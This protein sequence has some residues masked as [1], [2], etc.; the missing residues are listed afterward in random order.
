[1]SYFMRV[2]IKAL[3]LFFLRF[4]QITFSFLFFLGGVS[5]KRGYQHAIPLCLPNNC[6]WDSETGQCVQSGE[7]R[8]SLYVVEEAIEQLRTIKGKFL[9]DYSL[10]HCP[11]ALSFFHY[12]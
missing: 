7:E 6:T 1:M 3:S 11:M 4:F 2:S 10:F 12:I 8:R 9:S 5:S